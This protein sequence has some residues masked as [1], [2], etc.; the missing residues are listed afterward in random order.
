MAEG[1]LPQGRA[2]STG[3]RRRR[4]RIHWEKVQP[5][6]L[7]LPTI[8]LVA[9]FVYTFIGATFYVSLS[10]W[11]SIKPDFTYQGFSVYK[12]LFTNVRFQHDLRNMVVFTTIFLTGS[13]SL[14]LILAILLERAKGLGVLRNIFLFP[15]ALSFIVA[16]VTWQWIFNPASGVNQLI[17]K[18]GIN[19][20]LVALGGEPFAP[21]W[22]ADARVAPV[23]N[24]L[25]AKVIPAI[26][27]L[28]VK[29]GVPL[30]LIPVGIAAIWMFAGFT[31]AM[32]LAGL[33]MISKEVREAARVDGASEFQMY[34]HIIIPLLKPMTI[35][36]LIILGHIS[37]KIF[38]LIYAMAG[39]GA[40]FATEVPSIFVFEVTFKA[41]KYNTGSAASMVMLFL[42]AIVIVPYLVSQYREGRAS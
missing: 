5:V 7:L 35:T 42:V 14:G 26:G 29:I 16:G 8:V 23:L 32:Y 36:S 18:V 9:I 40:G 30:A 24:D 20:L 10:N 34:R 11:D 31:M 21:N 38:D 4:K 6:L 22:I 17:D 15:M 3:P 25:L 33:A 12:D 13:V 28:R 19:D 37:L 39:S 41:L 2:D 27:D 1:T